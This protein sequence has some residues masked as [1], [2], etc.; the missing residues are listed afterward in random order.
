MG[1]ADRSRARHHDRHLVIEVVRR[2]QDDLV[3]RV[4]HRQHRVHERLVAARGHQHA[5]RRPHLNPV[6]AR[7]LRLQ[8]VDQRGK[9]LDRTVSMV[10]CR[11]AE[12]ACGLD[13]L[14]RRSVR[15]DSLAERNGARGLGN[16]ASDDRNDRSLNRRQPK[17]LAMNGVHGISIP[18]RH[19]RRPTGHRYVSKQSAVTGRQSAVAVGS[20]SR[21]SQ[22]AVAVGSRS[23]QSQ[24]VGSRSPQSAVAVSSRSRQSRRQ[25][26]VS[27][28]VGS[29]NGSLIPD[30][31]PYPYGRLT[32]KMPARTRRPPKICGWGDGLAK[33][34]HGKDGG[35]RHLSEQPDGRDRCG[36]LAERVGKGQVGANVRPAQAPPPALTQA[37]S[38]GEKRPLV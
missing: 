5:A 7:E 32:T 26:A 37:P 18:P 12:P 34:R 14:R 1:T 2:R 25:S 28:P 4:R 3:A 33:Q 31:D 17:G 13:R 38:F 21:Q 11:A 30:P 9:T 24:S 22:S 29:D 10:A 20:R 8:K 16:P 27:S 6:L 35:G 15:H 19:V 36:Q 23:R